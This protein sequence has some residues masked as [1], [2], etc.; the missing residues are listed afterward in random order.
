[1]SIVFGAGSGG[2][3]RTV[4]PPLDFESSTSANSIIPAWIRCLVYTMASEKSRPSFHIGRCCVAVDMRRAIAC[5][6]LR[7]A[8]PV[9]AGE[10][11]ALR[12]DCDE[13]E[14]RLMVEV[15]RALKEGLRRT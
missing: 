1:M 9:Y 12:E 15:A 2:R 5:S 7:Q 4:S 14:L 11:A 8:G 10:L 13:R 3:T 6:I